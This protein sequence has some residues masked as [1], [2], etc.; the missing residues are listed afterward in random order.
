MA[1]LAVK[2]SQEFLRALH[3]AQYVQKGCTREEMQDFLEP[4]DR[5][6]SLE[7]ETDD[8]LRRTQKT[9]LKESSDFKELSVHLELARTI[10]ESTNSF[11]KA[12][13]IMRDHI[14]ES[15]NR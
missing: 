13:H 6:L 4:V 9:I 12:V 15:V 14:L 2:A 7:R 8:A 5:V 3:A 11:M 1:E 10:E